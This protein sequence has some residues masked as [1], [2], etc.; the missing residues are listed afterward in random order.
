MGCPSCRAEAPPDARFC[1]QCGTRL[2]STC[3]RCGHEVGPAAKFCQECGQPVSTDAVTPTPPTA[4]DAYTPRHLAEKILAGRDALAGE[5]KQVTVLFA[6]VVG[7][8]ELIDGRDAEEAQALLDGVVQ[9]M[10]DA[11]HRYEGTICRLMGD[12]LMALFGAPIAH[13][14][15]AVRA[16]YAALAMQEAAVEYSEQSRL[17]YGTDL[18]IRVGLNS[19]DVI[20]RLISDD[21]HMDYSAMGQTV[22]LAS[23]MEQLASRGHALLTASTLGLA[24][25]MVQVRSLGPTIVRGVTAP[26]EVFELV[27][28]RQ[29]R[30]RLE[31]RAARGLT[32]FVGRDNELAVLHRALHQASDGRGQMVA[33]IGDPGVGKSRLVR[34]IV[35]GPAT[36]GWLVLEAGCVSYGSTTAYLPIG[37]LLKT[38]GQI[39][40]HDDRAAIRAKLEARIA[41]FDGLDSGYVSALLSALGVEPD[42]EGWQSIPAG[43]RRRRIL[44]ACARLI[45]QESLIRPI[46]LVVEDLHWADQETPAVLNRLAH[47][48]PAAP[49]LLIVTYRPEYVHTWANLSHYSQLRIE[50]LPR[51]RSHELL[52]SL[53]GDDPS[54][55]PL[56]EF[57]AERTQGNPFFLEESVRTLIESGVLSGESGGFRLVKPYSESIVPDTV[58]AIVA[59]R[60]D[61]LLPDQKQVLQAAAVIGRDVPLALLRSVTDFQDDAFHRHLTHLQAAEFLFE[62]SAFPDP[63]YRFKHAI[64]RE[65]VYAGLLRGRRRALHQRVAAQLASD[66]PGAGELPHER[67]AFHF[68]LAEAWSEALPHL[69][70]AAVRAKHRSA[71]EEALAHYQQALEILEREAAT[72]W[73]E[74]FDLLSE[75]HGV[76]GIMSRHQDERAD[77]D[78]MR[79]LADEA[80]DERRLSDALNGLADFHNRTGNLEAARDAAE[81]ALI[82]KEKL[83]DRA[84]IA[85]AL[86]N[87]A[88]LYAA[89]ANFDAAYAANQRAL[90]IREEIG[91]LA[92]QIRSLD[93]L[94][95][96]RL[97]I[98]RFSE[99]D[100]YFAEALA[101]AQAVGYKEYELWTNIH[102]GA[103]FSNMGQATEAGG[104]LR[105]AIELSRELGNRAGEGWARFLFG[106]VARDRGEFD[107]A[108]QELTAAREIARAVGSPE[109]EVYT[110][111]YSGETE[112]LAERPGDALGFLHESI[113]LADVHGFLLHLIEGLSALALAALE[114]G[115]LDLARKQAARVIELLSRGGPWGSGDEQWVAWCLYKVLQADD[116]P[117]TEAYFQHV[118]ASLDARLAGIADPSQHDAFRDR[119]INRG[120]VEE[121]A[122]RARTEV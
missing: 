8:T 54:L 5:R 26:I 122:R 18:D 86:S 17:K 3:P 110:L 83:G 111:N 31:A 49:V 13:E 42:D 30:S 43:E 76:Y 98:G 1:Q 65:V 10:M 24:D 19:G 88:P 93:N 108:R 14:D 106:R 67:L 48:I 46:V 44:D 94:G 62:D 12:G 11:V 81:A 89:L 68:C 99:A 47:A 16:C 34:E 84:G 60:A 119:R 45:I 82:L 87:I 75:R 9:V 56:H 22:H 23:R 121:Q 36:T 101:R 91:D 97:F 51:Q 90:W 69:R 29:G 66:Q 80:G 50:P 107:V 40:L 114:L 38:C 59:A 105:R 61:R 58:Q 37:E 53:L 120:I 27:S 74:I 113:E 116:D 72:R 115:D 71:N 78:R 35:H 6:D 64:T 7:S 20:V 70:A 77:L 52:A 15:H 39:D 112:I 95:I 102:L 85:D 57:L 73:Q 117:R 118:C 109:L 2:A 33:V 100:A 55:G 32:G 28:S 96:N 4:P 103:N 25:G 104:V 63:S 41:A 79:D 92:G 21:L